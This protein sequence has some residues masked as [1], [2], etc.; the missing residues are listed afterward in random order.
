MKVEVEG[1]RE[2]E[3]LCEDV[4]KIVKSVIKRVSEE[5]RIENIKKEF[6]VGLKRELT[7]EELE[8]YLFR[9]KNED[10]NYWSYLRKLKEKDK[11]LKKESN[12]DTLSSQI[13]KID[14]S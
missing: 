3:T 13:G 11:L 5:E 4:P 12:D 7:K 2:T 1:K 10:E 9:F 8:V 14:N 6:K